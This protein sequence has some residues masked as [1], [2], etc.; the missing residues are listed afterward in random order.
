MDRT[1]VAPRGPVHG[2]GNIHTLRMAVETVRL[3]RTDTHSLNRPNTAQV[4]NDE[5]GQGLSNTVDWVNTRPD[6]AD[7]PFTLPCLHGHGQQNDA[8]HA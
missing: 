7:L 3:V 1:D 8:Q 5:A 2:D 6:K 4:H